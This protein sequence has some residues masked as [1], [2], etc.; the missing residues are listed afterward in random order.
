MEFKKRT[1]NTVKEEEVVEAPV[2]HRRSVAQ[3]EADTAA[4]AGMVGLSG[5]VPTDYIGDIT[6]HKSSATKK[7]FGRIT[8]EEVLEAI[9]NCRGLLTSV[10]R[11]LGISTYYVKQIF[12]KHKSLRQEFDEYREAFLDEVEQALYGKVLRGDTTAMIFTLKC[13]GKGRG[14]VEAV[15][16][17]QKKASVKM[18]I[19]PATAKSKKAAKV[20]LPENESKNVIAFK[21]SDG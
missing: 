17:S 15:V 16:G 19:V 6:Q 11:Q 20:S 1:V 18:K 7:V 13:L 21:A 4:E 9:R 5:S 12:S 2:F 8:Y 10:S 14:Y 3:I